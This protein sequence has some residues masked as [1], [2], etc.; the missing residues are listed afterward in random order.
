MEGLKIGI[1]KSPRSAPKPVR[2]GEGRSG[3]IHPARCP[4]PA[5]KGSPWQAINPYYYSPLE[6]WKG[7]ETAMKTAAKR[8]GRKKTPKQKPYTATKPCK[9]QEELPSSTFLQTGPFSSGHH[10][11]KESL[12]SEQ[13]PEGGDSPREAAGEPGPSELLTPGE[14][15]RQTKKRLGREGGGREEC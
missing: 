1:I 15:G 3:V 12:I 2:A 6:T 13:L 14:S 9:P 7:D 5:G 8:W 11:S 10:G 4:L